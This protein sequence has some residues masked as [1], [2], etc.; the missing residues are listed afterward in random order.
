MSLVTFKIT[1]S[2]TDTL[3]FFPLGVVFP[4]AIVMSMV[5]VS[6]ADGELAGLDLAGEADALGLPTPVGLA[7]A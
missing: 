3:I 1:F 2:P 7:D 5:S 6:L 4:F